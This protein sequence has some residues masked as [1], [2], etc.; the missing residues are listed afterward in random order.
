MSCDFLTTCDSNRL[1]GLGLKKPWG[2]RS[3]DTFR[4]GLL[5]IPKCGCEPAVLRRQHSL[6]ICI[7]WVQ[8]MQ[9]P[10]LHL[11]AG[12][13]AVWDFSELLCILLCV[14]RPCA[15]PWIARAAMDPSCK[16]SCLQCPPKCRLPLERCEYAAEVYGYPS[17]GQSRS[18]TLDHASTNSR[19]GTGLLCFCCEALLWCII[20]RKT[21][22]ICRL[23]HVVR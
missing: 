4:A 22:G 15:W 21:V 9:R 1:I 8:T 3:K 18:E 19:D 10:T 12:Q 14:A 20:S 17:E 13:L 6:Y 23:N 16:G 11:S 5:S 7:V 2:A